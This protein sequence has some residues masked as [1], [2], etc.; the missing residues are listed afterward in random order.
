M[1]LIDRYLAAVRSNLPAGR[2]DD[3]TA[4]LRGELLDRIEAREA[5][6]GRPL[7]QSETGALLKSFGRP[8]VVAT[9]YR[10]HQQLIGPEVYP[11]YL[12]ALRVVAVI[13]LAVFF[14]SAI[15]PILTGNADFAR[16]AA[17]GFSKAWSALFTAFAI[18]TMLFAVMERT[19][20]PRAWLSNWQPEQLPDTA[21]R[22]KSPWELPFDFGASLWLLL[23]MLGVIP[24]TADYTRNGMHIEPAAVWMQFYWPIL[25]IVVVR[26]GLNLVDWLRPAWLRLRT[27][28]G[29]TL[30]LG[31]L[32]LISL[33]LA[34][35]PWA[36]V[37]ATTS[38]AEQAVRA[39]VGI[40]IAIRAV[41]T[42]A[43]MVAGVRLFLG[44]YWLVMRRGAWRA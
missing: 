36:I 33:L 15:V 11:F 6:L 10:D 27:L 38:S 18:V 5:A 30:A 24:I 4:E 43:L 44:V 17:R 14:F 1:E 13:T 40:N 8:I 34:R 22:K 9:R 29:M 19:G 28:L 42:V 25:G 32:A 7:D 12:H 20:A 3:I 16:A 41:L 21:Q 35:G 23:W 2:A 39:G 26:L 37:T 31:E